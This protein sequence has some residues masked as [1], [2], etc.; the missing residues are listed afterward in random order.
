MSI[1]P[2]VPLEALWN[3][4]DLYLLDTFLLTGLPLLVETFV[5]LVVI[6]CEGSFLSL[7]VLSPDTIQLSRTISNTA[8]RSIYPPR[9]LYKPTH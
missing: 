2:H 8:D 7:L 9:T 3:E 1:Q 5:T 4:K 6:P